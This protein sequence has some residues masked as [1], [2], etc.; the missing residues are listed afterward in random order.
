M[1]QWNK[2]IERILMLDKS[3]RDDE[4]SK[5]MKK[6][7]YTSKQPRGGSSH[8]TFRKKGKYPVTIPKGNPVNIAYIELVRDAIEQDESEDEKDE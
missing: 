2:L 4:L 3:L 7:G 1:S 6:I 8:V 5:A